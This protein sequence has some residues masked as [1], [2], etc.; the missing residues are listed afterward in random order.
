MSTN[1]SQ[2]GRKGGNENATDEP[3]DPGGDDGLQPGDEILS[4]DPSTDL[5]DDPPT[6]DPDPPADGRG[7]RG[8]NADGDTVP[9]SLD[10]IATGRIDDSGLE[11]SLARNRTVS[12]AQRRGI[13]VPAFDGD[14]STVSERAAQ[15]ARDRLR[16]AG[17]DG[18][19]TTTV[20][21]GG[22]GTVTGTTLDAGL[23][24]L[25]AGLGGDPD[26]A[27]GGVGG[28]ARGGFDAPSG[29]EIRDP[30]GGD[31]SGGGF[32][33]AEEIAAAEQNEELVDRA[34]TGGLLSERGENA[35]LLPPNAT[36]NTPRGS[37][38]VDI[39]ETR[40]RQGTSEFVNNL[41]AGAAFT[42]A[43][44][45]LTGNRPVGAGDPA[46]ESPI[47][48]GVE[49]GA[50]LF[51]AALPA[52][53]GQAET[54]AE[55]AQSAPGIVDDFSAGEIGE[56]AVATGRDRAIETATRARNNPAE[57]AGGVAAGAVLGAGALSRGRTGTLRDAVR[58]EVD[59][60]IGPFGTTAETNAA[61]AV[62][63]FLDDD[64]GQ[65][66]P[67]G[68]FGRDGG[69]G[70]LDPEL[71]EALT[72]FEESGG[73]GLPGDPADVRRAEE[74]P[75]DDIAA[76]DPIQR[77]RGRARREDADADTTTGTLGLD[78]RPTGGDQDPLSDDVALPFEG[79]RDAEAGTETGL[80]LDPDAGVLGGAAGGLAGDAGTDTGGT[81]DTGDVL[82]GDGSAGS[83]PRV[84]DPGTADPPTGTDTGPDL[85]GDVGPD[86]RGSDPEVDAGGTT[87]EAA[88][89]GIDDVGARVQPP[90][91]DVDGRI[92]GRGDTGIDSG[93][94][95]FG[96][97]DTGIDTGTDTRIDTGTDTRIDTDTRTLD[98]VERRER[99]RVE[100]DPLEF[101][102]V[103]RRDRGRERERERGQRRTDEEIRRVGVDAATVVN[104]TQSLAAVDENLQEM[105]DDGP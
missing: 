66:D 53:A 33:V 23:Q 72:N 7:G 58:A 60:R 77:R 37:L 74:Q 50:R 101:D 89:P 46:R 97:T 35:G 51:G 2:P 48:E 18:S 5:R 59:P 41:D 28:G 27:T 86:S 93:A 75:R 82:G 19:P 16:G 63:N 52:A 105:F 70:G 4:D 31:V 11:G 57:F 30:R 80:E 45:P 21:V 26:V 13:S 25:D 15:Q 3:T 24:G 91:V 38:T 87:V 34:T 65:A 73:T 43:A 76:A 68:A 83:D 9:D 94:D 61:R 17:Q 81:V 100:R 39:S 95:Q 42:S 62:R 79:R 29:G 12:L 56:T 55:T 32:G 92:D 36:A 54:V 22:A 84:A 90:D 64:R 8:G 20:G 104:P 44:D 96:R 69:D 102:P 103:D 40:L 49:G 71:E 1:N 47:E 10:E 88:F 6:T 78:E 67:A 98:D 85:G 99:D 14:F